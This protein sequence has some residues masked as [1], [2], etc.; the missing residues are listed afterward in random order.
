MKMNVLEIICL[1]IWGVLV[2][3]LASSFGYNLTLKAKIK[4]LDK[5]VSDLCRTQLMMISKSKELSKDFF[6]K[7]YYS[8]NEGS[9]VHIRIY[10]Y[11]SGDFHKWCEKYDKR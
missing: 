4:R 7:A 9:P 2:V 6:P 1:I 8:Y 3:L 10:P 5:T 11:K